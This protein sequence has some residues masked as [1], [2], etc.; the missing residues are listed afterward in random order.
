M[1]TIDIFRDTSY[2]GRVDPAERKR[3]EAQIANDTRLD[4]KHELQKRDLEAYPNIIHNPKEGWVH[5]T[6]KDHDKTWPGTYHVSIE[7]GKAKVELRFHKDQRESS[8]AILATEV[9]KKKFDVSISDT[10]PK[11]EW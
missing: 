1:T 7:D 6:H 2:G 9:L 11:T 8:T 10:A 4:V 5:G 3:R